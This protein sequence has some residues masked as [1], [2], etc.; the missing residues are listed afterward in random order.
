MDKVIQLGEHFWE[1]PPAPKSMEDVFYAKLSQRRQYWVRDDTYPKV[2]LDYNPTTRP[3]ADRTVYDRNTG[4]LLTM[5]RE[6]TELVLRL[7]D[8]ELTRRWEG[9]WF[10]NDGELTYMTGSHYFQL[11]WGAC[12]DYENP[13][14]GSKYGEYREYMRDYQYFRKMCLESVDDYGQRNCAGMLVVKPKKTAI[15]NTEALNYLDESTRMK[16]KMFGMMSKSSDDV[17][18]TGFAYY[19]YG[20]DH[21]PFIMQPIIAKRNESQIL[22]AN[23]RTRPSLSAKAILHQME[24]AAGFNTQVFTKGLVAAAF[25]GPVMERYWCDEWTK[26]IDPYP[27]EVRKKVSQT[28][29]KQ[30]A[31]RGLGIWTA[32]VSETDGRDFTEAKQIWKE[33]MLSTMNQIT[34]RTKSEFFAYCI[35]ADVA[36][37][38]SFDI[39]GKPDRERT[40]KIIMARRK[41]LEDDTAQLQAYMRQS[42]LDAEE[43]W[44]EG[45]GSTGSFNLLRLGVQKEKIR[46]RL[47]VGDLPYIPGTLEWEDEGDITLKERFE[48]NLL[49]VKFV[50]TPEADRLKG[51]QGPCRMYLH[52]ILP[53]DSFNRPVRL[54]L[55]DPRNGLLTPGED[56]PFIGATDPT[57]YAFKKNVKAPSMCASTV[58]NFHN[59]AINSMFGKIVTKRFVF[60]YLYRH[61]SPVKTLEDVV[62]KMLFFGCWEA[63]ESNREWMYTEL[64]LLGLQNFMLVRNPKTRGIEPYNPREH[65]DLLRTVSAGNMNVIEDYV[66]AKVS[67][68]AQPSGGEPDYLELIEDEEQL[69]Q[70]MQFKVEDT[71]K[72]DLSVCSS[73]NILALESFFAYLERIR[74]LNK[75]RFDPKMMEAV[76]S[77][78]L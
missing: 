76:I 58:M 63:V 22:F 75:Q 46:K 72:F 62:K 43:A 56:T 37:D 50:E 18:D 20:L 23:Q 68:Y 78:L 42:P 41:Q 9:I 77:R 7:R 44:R 33:S 29:K 38:T 36:G 35:T 4:L 74:I 57:E 14:T 39:H 13:Y 64:T 25:D 19:L 17:R 54:N 16:D 26:Y 65:Q 1:L 67:Y 51:K 34:S 47:T 60:R 27:E 52:D 61:E 8:Q 32:Y 10:M 70:D 59:S 53:P 71:R 3:Y 2:F 30:E 24:N 5:S 11:Q 69:E 40:M 49:L 55:R 73:W 12:K 28:V 15:T 21:L 6:D 66:K 45:G 48:N 31:I